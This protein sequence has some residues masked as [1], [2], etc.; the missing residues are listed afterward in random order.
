MADTIG[1]VVNNGNGT[2]TINFVTTC[3]DIAG[4][5]VTIPTKQKTT[6]IAQLQADLDRHNRAAHPHVCS[7]TE[8]QA[9]ITACQSAPEHTP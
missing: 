6:T 3:V 4:A 8:I 5:T 9:E 1:S 2:F 7:A